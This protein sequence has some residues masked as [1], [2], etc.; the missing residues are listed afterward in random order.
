MNDQMTSPNADASLEAAL[1]AVINK[2]LSKGNAQ[3][4]ARL[5]NQMVQLARHGN[6]AETF[7][8]NTPEGTDMVNFARLWEHVLVQA[9]RQTRGYVAKTSRGE[10]EQTR[11]DFEDCIDF[12]VNKLRSAVQRHKLDLGG[13]NFMS[14]VAQRYGI[15]EKVKKSGSPVG[16]SREGAP[17]LDVAP[18]P[19]AATRP[20]RVEA[21]EGAP[22]VA[23]P[24]PAPMDV[25]T[26]D[27]L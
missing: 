22:E 26:V 3:F 6:S 21:A 1:G 11:K 14:R 10:F 16:Q 25:P 9:D 13:T 19:K 15:T 17:E 5:L 4:R 27:D 23:K 2:H 18:K 8:R 7:I 24:A 12:M 20:Q